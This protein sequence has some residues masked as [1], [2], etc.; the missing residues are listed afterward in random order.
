MAEFR[1]ARGLDRLVNFSDAAVAIAITLL[2]LPL[3]DIASQI[4]RHTL[5]YVLAHNVGTVTGFVVT[6][7]VIGRF[8]MVHHEVFEWVADYDYQLA[9]VNMLWLFSIVFLPFA[10]NLL[11]HVNGQSSAVF[12]LYVG[13]MVVASGS[14]TLMEWML[15]RRPEL[16]RPEVRGKV[17]LLR[18]MVP[19]A[20][21]VVALILAVLVPSVGLF[22]L[23]LLF[24]ASPIEQLVRKV[25]PERTD[26]V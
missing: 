26:A 9:W 11:S 22:W 24:G 13:T 16:M 8:W 19:T 6:F 4:E 12:G 15:T 7:A 2:I 25:L 20:L 1:T 10:A 5:G 17:D 3:V 18:S 21:L 23:L 14:L